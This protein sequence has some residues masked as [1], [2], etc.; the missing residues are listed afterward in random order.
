MVQRNQIKQFK[1]G[2]GWDRKIIHLCEMLFDAASNYVGLHKR[3]L[4]KKDNIPK[5][6]LC[7]HLFYSIF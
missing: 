2:Q 7:R 3:L 1:I 5:L 4:A 6:F